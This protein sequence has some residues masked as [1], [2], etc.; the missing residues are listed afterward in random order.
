VPAEVIWSPIGVDAL[1]EDAEVTVRAE[2]SRLV[3]AGPGAGKTELLAQ[4]AAYLLQ[5]GTCADPQRILALSFKRDAARNLAERVRRRIGPTLAARLDS[6]TFDAFAKGMVDRFREA[7]PADWRPTA[8]Y[9]IDFR[10]PSNTRNAVLAIPDA[11]LSVDQRGREALAHKD[12]IFFRRYVV[13]AALPLAPGAEDT[14]AHVVARALWNHRLHGLPH[15]SE[16]AFPM[17]TRLAQLILTENPTLLAALRGTYGFVFL[18]EFQDTTG[19]QYLFTR[20]AFMGTSTVI[21]AVG[22]PKQCVMRWAGA[23]PRVFPAIKKDFGA[24]ETKLKQNHRSASSLVAVQAVVARRIDADAPVVEAV[25]E[26]ANAAAECLLLEYDD[27][28]EEAADLAA[29]IDHWIREDNLNP[30]TSAC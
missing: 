29:R 4:R 21:T 1:E 19:P 24:I 26:G 15:G 10:L 5:T 13:G 27:A 2:N 18:D 23:E 7:L 20:T 30:A 22:D 28:Q 11:L 17:I 14:E 3:I 12:G 16:L 6:F 9:G 8:G 25:G